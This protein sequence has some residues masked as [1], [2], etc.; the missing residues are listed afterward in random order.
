MNGVHPP[1]ML[2][3]SA[4]QNVCEFAVYFGERESCVLLCECE[5]ECECARVCEE[6]KKGK[7]RELKKERGE[8]EESTFNCI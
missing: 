5:C 8:R 6:E 7:G 1:L 4:L 3:P 2:V